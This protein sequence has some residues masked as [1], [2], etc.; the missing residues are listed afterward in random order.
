MTV[1]GSVTPPLRS[2]GRPPKTDADQEQLKEKIAQ[3]TLAAFGEQGY[4]ELKV[5]HVLEKANISRPTFYKYF[6]HLEE[7]LQIAALKLHQ[8]LYHRI[9]VAFEQA[10]DPIWGAMLACDAYVDWGKSLGRLVEALYAEFYER[11]SPIAKYRQQ[12]IQALQ[13][14]ITQAVIQSGRP[15]PSETTLGLFITGVEFLA[16]QFL[17]ES[18]R[19]DQT[20]AQTRMAILK[21]LLCCFGTEQDIPLLIPLLKA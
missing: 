1:D 12:V 17:L 16:F 7:P 10:S 21:L 2:R 11:S 4:R 14:L 8:D 6:R 9:E 19:S 13:G 15:R 18:D 20:Y 3:A 5:E